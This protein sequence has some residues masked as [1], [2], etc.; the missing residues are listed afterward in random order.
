MSN[1]FS[2]KLG[3]FRETH[4]TQEQEKEIFPSQ[5]MMLRRSITSLVFIYLLV[6]SGM[7]WM[8]AR[9]NFGLAF[10]I[11]C[12][13]F[14]AALLGG[15]YL[16][17]IRQSKKDLLKNPKVWFIRYCCYLSLLSFFWG[18]ISFFPIFLSGQYVLA[19]FM[20]ITTIGIIVTVPKTAS[21]PYAFISFFAPVFCMTFIALS[22]TD[23]L[24]GA[25]FIYFFLTM[26]VIIFVAQS[27]RKMSLRMISAELKEVKFKK[28]LEMAN[29][30]LRGVGNNMGLAILHFTKDYKVLLW[31]KTY[32]E[33]FNFPEGILK[34]QIHLRKC[35]QQHAEMIFHKNS[36][37]EEYV[38]GRMK[39]LE[40]GIGPDDFFTQI[41]FNDGGKINVHITA[42]EDESVIIA[43]SNVTRQEKQ[44]TEDILHLVQHDDLTALPNRLY[45]KNHLKTKINQLKSDDD[46]I[47]IFHFGIDSFK[48]VNDTFGHNIGDQLII[49]LTAKMNKIKDDHSF[50]A[51]LGGDE[52][53]V[54][55]T[56]LSSE[57]KM[58]IFA[59]RLVDMIAEPIN[60]SDR[61]LSVKACMGMVLLSGKQD[62]SVDQSIRNVNIALH[63]AK[64][65]GF[66]TMIEYK[67]EMHSKVLRRTFLQ[68]DIHDG[69]STSQFSLQYQPQIEIRSRKIIGVE[70]LMRWNHPEH[71]SISPDEFI[72][73]AE[74]SKQI[75]PLTEQLIPE[76]CMQSQ[77]WA[78]QGLSGICMSVNIS[79]V[80]FDDSELV[81]FI[82]Y[83]L[84][85]SELDPSNLE[86]EITEGVVMKQSN[87]VINSLTALS[88]LGVKMAIDDFGKGYSSLSYLRR[89]PVHKLKID[90]EFVD[91]L[92]QN[93]KARQ[94][95]DAIIKLG[96][97][98]NL[99]VIAEGVET[100]EQLDILEELGC[101]QAQGYYISRPKTAD[102]I[103]AWIKE[104][105][106]E[107]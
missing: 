62:I 88:N 7:V 16:F 4:L 67:P 61:S 49:E 51:R 92:G 53:A 54:I 2:E 3:Y 44:R 71:G 40:N 45:F 98:F 91:D 102:N 93:K 78:A 72:A 70:A 94:V 100:A 76:A 50:I 59:K 99:K 58:R 21:H 22:F 29:E 60:I 28:R 20:S 43:Y 48:D 90:K 66:G 69:M 19:L 17:I 87:A 73:V 46:K 33:L 104:N 103:T 57:Q 14:V 75:I 65:Q 1:K 105:R 86:L 64:E 15:F 83:C 23:H 74:F 52:F 82:K 27:Y 56:D 63:N 97:S 30:L 26:G 77:L 8:G 38:D 89:L 12:G 101:D 31:N 39:M 79:P 80:H 37:S 24:K 85:E 36:T 34:P 18:G 32:E 42:L 84:K 5:L 106:L 95:I 81:D 13:S 47:C 55:K 35:L 107:Y 41:T 25:M 9:E 6:F 11:W 96:H 10:Y 68:S